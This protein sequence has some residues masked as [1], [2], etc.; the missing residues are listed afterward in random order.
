MHLASVV[1][2]VVCV[3]LGFAPSYSGNGAFPSASDQWLGGESDLRRS[4]L[5]AGR[6]TLD[7]ADFLVSMLSA[8][9]LLLAG[10]DFGIGFGLQS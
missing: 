8:A 6:A 4:G 10:A 1:G 9:L 5:L 7:L 3:L 2:V